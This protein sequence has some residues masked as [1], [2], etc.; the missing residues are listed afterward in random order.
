MPSSSSESPFAATL[1]LL[2]PPEIQK[3]AILPKSG[4][5][6]AS[7]SSDYAMLFTTLLESNSLLLKEV[8]HLKEEHQKTMNM[9]THVT[10][11][12]EV[13]GTNEEIDTAASTSS[14]NRVMDD[15]SSTSLEQMVTVPAKTC[16]SGELVLENVEGDEEG[17][18][19]VEDI[20]PDKFGS[21]SEHSATE[22]CEGSSSSSLTGPLLTVKSYASPRIESMW[23][24]FSVNDYMQD[25]RAER[26]VQARS[27]EWTPKITIPQPF[28]MMIRESK[29]PRRKNILAAAVEK[30]RIEKEAL[31]K[32]ELKKQFRANPIPAT[33]FLPLYELFNAKND[34]RRERIRAQSSMKLKASEKPFKFMKREEQKQRHR[35][36]L[37]KR[38]QVLEK[39]MQREEK[40]F[41]ARPAPVKLLSPTKQEELQEKEDYR[42]LRIKMRSE[43]LLASSKL[44]D[45]MQ[46]SNN[47][48]AKKYEGN[49]FSFSPKISHEIPDYNRA[50]NRLQQELVLRKSAKKPTVVSP[51]RLLTEEVCAKR[52]V[53]KKERTMA[54]PPKSIPKKRSTSASGGR[55]MWYSP[56]MTETAKCRVSLTKEKLAEM[57]RKEALE[58]EERRAKREKQKEIQRFV[59]LKSS[60]SAPLLE[61]RRKEKLQ[62]FR[63]VIYWDLVIY[64]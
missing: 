41:K 57:V 25:E 39:A 62:E 26:I 28:S 50:Y 61:D 56:Q 20:S 43:A 8:K 53:C 30:E 32:A 3:A 14:L 59:S 23:D 16:E 24:D 46:T 22:S 9:L 4:P 54:A 48:K 52:E 18:L 44:P 27:K 49:K 60:S 64:V 42:K 17:I 63:S 2:S 36:E 40:A 37:L 13:Q 31:E 11:S 51:F 15:N 45:N 34:Q 21:S 19:S 12:A 33:T 7:K 1:N 47:K 5:P 10:K 29:I 38:T 58:E 6:S 55:T 35:H